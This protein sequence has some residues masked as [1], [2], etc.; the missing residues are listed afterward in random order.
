MDK[1]DLKYIL[2]LFPIS[3][4]A[5]FSNIWVRPADLMEARNFITAREMIENNNFIIPTLNGFLRFEKPPFPTW[6]TAWIMKIT[7]NIS[8]EYILRIPVALCSIL[9]IILLY[10]FVKLMTKDRVKS[11]ITSFVGTTTFMIIK[12]GN[13]N[14]WDIYT[15]IFAFG[16]ITFMV[17]G[18][19]NEKLKDFIMS[20]IFISISILSK[21]PVG[22]YGLIFPFLISYTIIFGFKDYKKNLKNLIIMLVITI[23]LSSIWAFIVYFKYPEI[24]LNIL[25]KEKATWTSRHTRSFIY[26]IDYFVYMGIWIFFSVMAVIYPWSKNRNN[27]KNFSKFIFIWNILV[28]LFLSFIKMKKK[29]YG[30]PIYM[31]SIIEVGMIC[32]YYYN[33]FWYELKKSDKILLYIQGIFMT[34]ICFAIPCLLYL[35]GYLKGIV[36]WQYILIIFL[37]FIPFGYLTINFFIKKKSSLI[38]FIIFGSGMLLLIVNLTTN[39]FIEENII[40]KTNEYI[41]YKKIKLVRKNPPIFDIYGKNYEIE[42]V[43]R[44]GKKI[45][46][47][48]EGMKLPNEFIFFDSIPEEILKEYKLLKK[49]IYVKDNGNLAELNYLKKMEE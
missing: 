29:R 25:K 34:I 23:I 5:F 38:K 24:F 18:F 30:V 32:S 11:F 26:Y 19:Q 20:G 36:N 27:D 16:A 10:Y 21:G 47:Y 48:E 37:I 3:V 28:I 17:K 7:G 49:E 42:D 9:F 8:D 22:I 14:T 45:K 6:L 41:D 44:V 35:K 40:R 2:V 12:V 39:W 13:E 43:W 46:N 4:F 1:K 33:K 31:T 15:Y